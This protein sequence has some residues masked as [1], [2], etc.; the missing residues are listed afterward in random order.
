MWRSEQLSVAL[1]VS[2]PALYASSMRLRSHGAGAA[3]QH[4]DL[5]RLSSAQLAK[6]TIAKKR[7]I[8][9]EGTIAKRAQQKP[10]TDA[11]SATSSEPTHQWQS[12]EAHE[13]LRTQPTLFEYL[14]AHGGAKQPRCTQ[15]GAPGDPDPRNCGTDGYLMIKQ[16]T[17]N[18]SVPTC[19]TQVM[20]MRRTS[21]ELSFRD[22]TMCK[23]TSLLDG[24]TSADQRWRKLHMM[25][26]PDGSPSM[27]AFVD[28]LC[29]FDH[30]VTPPRGISFDDFGRELA[31][32]TD[33]FY[34]EEGRGSLFLRYVTPTD[35]QRKHL[36]AVHGTA[37]YLYIILVCAGKGTGMG[38][39]L[40]D[41]AERFG[42]LLGVTHIVL[43]ALP[44]V[45]SYYWK[46]GYG[47]VTRE[48]TL[49]DGRP[50]VGTDSKGR[51]R[52]LP[53]TRPVK[54]L[55]DTLSVKSE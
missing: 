15:P 6:R 49:L 50:W 7:R 16:I 1:G 5:K 2:H 19:P 46:L 48:G 26:Q 45:L 9:K 29:I 23:L 11:K 55:A 25:R 39:A 22:R 35:A 33:W 12:V 42:L 47:F 44:H 8:A 24:A 20:A 28:R 51:P 53:E 14:I 32:W 40:V 34:A 4:V 38:Q 30:D 41:I 21:Y 31:N 54:P 37:G 10:D 3:T 36:P 27:T 43:S 17:A 52:L 13:D 18:A